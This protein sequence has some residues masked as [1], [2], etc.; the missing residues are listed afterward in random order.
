MK[1]QKIILKNKVVLKQS[2]YKEINTIVE[3]ARNTAAKAVN[4]AMVLAYWEIGKRI[5]QEEQRGSKKA[6]Y[7]DYLIKDLSKKLSAR[8]GKGFTETNLKYFRQF[9]LTFSD[10]QISHAVRDQS[11]KKLLS[12][13]SHAVRDQS[14]KPEI[15]EEYQFLRS[16]LSWTHY[17]LLM[18]VENPN[19]RNYY[20]NESIEQNWSTRVL[21]RQI[22]TFYY[23][24]ILSSKNKSKVKAEIQKKGNNIYTPLD[25][26]KDP[27]VFEFLGVSEKNTYSEKDLETE[28]INKLQYFLLELGKGFS[29]VSRQKRISAD[30]EHFYIDLVF[31][32]YILKCFVLIDLKVGKLTHQDIGQMDMYVRYWE[33]N[34]KNENDCPTIGLILCSQKNNTV[35][36]YS[37]LKGSKQLYASKYKLY[38]PTEKELIKEIEHELQQ[39]KL[40]KHKK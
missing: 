8:Y 29:F 6:N 12:Q 3:Q 27:F 4:F 33:E 30:E 40:N 15:I 18:G 23:E 10:Y 35:A 26:L 17:R 20:I 1:K 25:I 13:I 24:R 34:E 2:F 5:V 19:A 9:Y 32:N 39:L 22:N 36:K 21:E 14:I 37:V 31:Y 11:Q 7:G 28:L 38:L 16:E